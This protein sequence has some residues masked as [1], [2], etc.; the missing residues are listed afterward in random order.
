MSHRPRPARVAQPTDPSEV[1]PR[2]V[3][4]FRVV[5]LALGALLAV[6]IVF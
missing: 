1:S 3:K 4:V 6:E 2:V 5:L